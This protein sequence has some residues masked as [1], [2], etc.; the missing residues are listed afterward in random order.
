MLD[1]DPLCCTPKIGAIARFINKHYALEAP[2]SCKLLQR[3]LNDVYLACNS[4]E[5]YIFRLSHRR[6]RGPAD[7]RSETAFLVHLSNLGVPVVEPVPTRD[8]MLFVQG[9]APEGER[10][11]VLFREIEGRAPDA[12]DTGD[13]WA[14]GKTLALIHDAAETYP[15][16]GTLYQLDL[17]HL[18]HQPLARIRES[19]VVEDTNVL[20]D[21]ELLAERTTVA[22]KAF[23]SLTWT[24][25]HGDCHGFNS[26]INAAGEAVF[27]DFD[28]GGPGYLAYDLAV[29]LWAQVSF[30][31]SSVARW[32]AFVNGYRSVRA[33][34]SVDFE[35]AISFV[36]VRQFWLM[37]E[38][39]SRAGEWGSNNVAWITRELD[40]LKVWEMERL[41]GRLF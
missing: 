4:R 37:G 30:G 5:R 38:H 11:G 20:G 18:L 33:I 12:S 27:F 25:C 19:G 23:R 6:A 7:V 16:A 34:N 24:Y 36:I 9:H 2:V 32:L 17:E 40:F 13:A 22:I 15:A 3:G 10:D 8:G 31:R 29:F 28:D 35:A 21:L 14:N 1:F 26:R 39:A 41:A